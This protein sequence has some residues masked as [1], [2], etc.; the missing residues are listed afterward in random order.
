M[1]S[2]NDFK[3]GLTIEI[4]GDIYQIVD[5]QHVKPGKGS[6]FVRTKVK[7]VK[8][9]SIVEKKFNAGE[10][11]AKARLDRREMQ[12]LYKDGDQFVVM[13]NES[14]EQIMLTESQIGDE[15]KWL[16]EN[17]NL[18]ILIYNNEVIGVD[19]PNTV[20]L[21]VTETDPGVRGDTAQGGT[22]AAVVE[23]G[24][25]VQVPFFINVDDELVIDTRTGSYVSRA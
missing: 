24:A 7:N 19:L 20:V 1:I 3:T 8:T 17:M 16:K 2:S 23:T 12:Y 4:D 18:G 22:K 9:G 13:D 11:F 25:T 21:R 14:Y 5:F 15:V 10:K 6:A